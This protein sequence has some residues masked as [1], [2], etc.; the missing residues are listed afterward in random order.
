MTQ[1]KFKTIKTTDVRKGMFVILPLS[2]HQHPFLTNQF[3]VKSDAEIDKI[4]AMKI[5]EIEVDPD[6]SEDMQRKAPPDAWE[7]S[8][9]A[10]KIVPDALKEA[11]RDTQAPPDR[12][13]AS[14][15]Q[16]SIAMMKNLLDNPTAE[17]ISEAKKG[18]SEIVT[19]ILKEEDT[20][21]HLLKI[22][23]YD[24]YTYTHSVSVGV[25]AVALAKKLFKDTKNHDIQALG[26]GFFLHDMG[27]VGIDNN[28][29]NKPG[30]LDDEEWREMRRHPS[31]GFK[32]LHDTR[33]LTDECRIIVL[34]H[35]ERVDGTGYPK[36]L[37]GNDIHI[38][39]R[40][41]AIADV[42]DALTS[43]RPYRKKMVPFDALKLMRE[44]M[45]QH[46]QKDLFEQFVRLFKPPDGMQAQGKI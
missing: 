41:C 42:Y 5:H 24:H 1:Q 21:Y 11:L 46:F 19:L 27:K 26:A 4:K 32:L 29:I 40:I 9:A 2:W 37:R 22:T 44:Q 35:H 38:Y 39:A 31:L 3:V 15:R 13:A 18:I 6:R 17:N 36:G 34:Q 33:Q 12:K 20:I 16:E 7:K 28:I 30:K 10:P 45:M 8:E 25:L 23:S 43:D 14:I